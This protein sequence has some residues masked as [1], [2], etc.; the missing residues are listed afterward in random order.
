MYLAKDYR[1][2]ARRALGDSWT[3]GKWVTF[4]LIVLINALIF[5]AVNSLDFNRF[6]AS[7]ASVV[8]FLIGGPFALGMAKVS[9]N[10]VRG[11]E[12]KIEML[13][14]GF[15]DFAR[16]FVLNLINGLLILLGLILFIVPGIILA[17]SYSMSFYILHDNPD[18]SANEA[19]IRSAELMKGNKLRLFCLQVSFIGWFILGVLTAG[20]LLLWVTPY[21]KTAEAC[22][23]SSLVQTPST[24]DV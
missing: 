23:Y 8:T 5:G 1:D 14:D 7:V 4:V 6:V 17:Y 2:W 24:I 22:F 19:R 16:S 12:I 20:I 9:L 21:Y 18:M 15:K 3:G 10:V 13:F 11:F